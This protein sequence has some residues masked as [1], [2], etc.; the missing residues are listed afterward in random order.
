MAKPIFRHGLMPGR[1][2][3][4]TF[5]TGPIG[6]RLVWLHEPGT[7]LDAEWFDSLGGERPFIDTP[8]LHPVIDGFQGGQ[9]MVRL[10][11]ALEADL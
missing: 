3:F 9:C 8:V 10:G 4:L 6:L 7:G 11:M 1:H 5:G 2:Q